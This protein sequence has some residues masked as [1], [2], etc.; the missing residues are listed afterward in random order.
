LNY[1]GPHTF[2]NLREAYVSNLFWWVVERL[3]PVRG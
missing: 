3:G 1:P 2:E